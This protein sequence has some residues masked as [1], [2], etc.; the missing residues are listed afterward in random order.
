MVTLRM[1]DIQAQHKKNIP[2]STA[3]G[4]LLVRS[5]PHVYLGGLGLETGSSVHSVGQLSWF[6][7]PE[8]CVHSPTFL[9]F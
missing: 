5:A 3:H 4:S 1:Y 9:L 7:K 6:L 2:L 8:V